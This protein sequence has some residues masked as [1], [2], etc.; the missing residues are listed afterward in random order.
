[1][2]RRN[3]TNQLCLMFAMYEDVMWDVDELPN[4]DIMITET[5]RLVNIVRLGEWDR[6]ANVQIIRSHHHHN[7]RPD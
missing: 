2:A 7:R 4:G 5:D 1:M 6:Y 3:G